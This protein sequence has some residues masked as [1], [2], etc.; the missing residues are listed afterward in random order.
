MRFGAFT[1]RRITLCPH[2]AVTNQSR[3]PVD[4]LFHQ[5]GMGSAERTSRMGARLSATYSA[6]FT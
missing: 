3:R 4:M 1:Q 5:P 2:E 6:P